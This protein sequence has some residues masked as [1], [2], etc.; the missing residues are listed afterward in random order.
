MVVGRFWIRAELLQP[1]RYSWHPLTNVHF[2]A[3]QKGFM[4]RQHDAHRVVNL[5]VFAF[6]ERL[7]FRSDKLGTNSFVC[8][9]I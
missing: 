4:E 7:R 5:A 3:Q 2:E 1:Q 9:G 6:S 8:Q